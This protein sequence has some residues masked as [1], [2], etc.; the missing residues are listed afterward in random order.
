[1]KVFDRIQLKSPKRSAFDLSH[2]RKFSMNMGD[3]VPVLCTE[4]IPNDK[5]RLN[6]EHLVRMQ[7]LLAPMMHHVNVTTH[8][9][10]VPNRLIWNDWENFITGG[11]KGNSNPVFPTL[12]VTNSIQYKNVG[13]GIG[14]LADYLGVP[15]KQ[16]EGKTGILQPNQI[17]ALPFRAYQLIYNEYYRDQNL[18]EPVEFGKSSGVT[19]AGS[20]SVTSNSP[21]RQLLRLRKRAWEK[22]YFTS[23]L[24][25]AQKGEQMT[26][27]ITGEFPVKFTNMFG[28]NSKEVKATTNI[29]GDIDLNALNAQ[30]EAGYLNTELTG[31][32][33]TTINELRAASRIQ[34]WAEKNARSGNRYVELILSHFGIK[35]SDARLQRPE[36]LGGGKTPITISEVLQNSATEEDS[37]QG[38]M[39]GHGVSPGSTNQFSRRFEEHGYII[40]IMSIMP[41]TGYYQG[42]PRHFMKTDKFEFAWPDL[43]H[44]GEQ[45]V[46]AGE[47]YFSPEQATGN[48]DSFGYQPR[49]SEYRFINDTVHGDFV[50]TLKY[51]HMAREF[52]ERPYLNESFI[53]ANPTNRVF[54]VTDPT[55]PK[56][57]VQTYSKMQAIR[58]LPKYGN[59]GML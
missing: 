52:E 33:G 8:F 20:L 5:I 16:F 4:V 57:L 7:P 46:H 21:T 42:I 12:K 31:S 59:P 27:P 41:R 13:L 18:E 38:N 3:L 58:S 50:D 29:D 1:M 45:Q 55:Y 32:T 37:P 49:Y 19:E 28:G 24:P 22:D 10:F 9:F 40:G 26:I 56:L 39:A 25:F 23:A 2:G 15:V 35:S 44:M 36:Y 17:S 43:A 14:S 30:N 54:A 6:M 53:K 11:E 47:I 51:W 34:R 48:R